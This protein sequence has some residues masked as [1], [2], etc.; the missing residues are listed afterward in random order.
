MSQPPSTF[1]GEPYQPGT[2]DWTETA[3]LHRA[4]DGGGLLDG[5]KA[6]RQGALAD[7]VRFIALL[8]EGERDAYAIERQS[9]HRLSTAEVMELYALADFPHA[10]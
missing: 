6:L 5:L 4:D 8:P 10:A 1:R 9:D 2:I 7:L 3:S